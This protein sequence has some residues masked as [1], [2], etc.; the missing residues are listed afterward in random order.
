MLVD[1][2]FAALEL[3]IERD[4]ILAKIRERQ[5]AGDSLEQITDFLR[6]MRD[7]AILKAQDEINRA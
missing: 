3:K 1:V 7:G 4:V 2:A 5:A 6:G